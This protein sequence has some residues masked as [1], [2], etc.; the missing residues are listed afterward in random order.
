V[1]VNLFCFQPFRF[2]YHL[3]TDE[4]DREYEDHHVT[5]QE[6]W[7]VPTIKDE[8]RIASNKSHDETTGEGIPCTKWLPPR[9]VWERVTRESLSLTRILEFDESE[10]HDG[11]IDKLG[12]SDLKDLA[13]LPL[14]KL[15]TTHQAYEPAQNHGGVVA[16]LQKAQQC[17]QEDNCN[18]IDGHPIPGTFF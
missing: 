12:S 16:D 2:L 7:D 3:P 15:D 9:F 11:K 10:S 1:E 17:D 18:A 4:Q 8:D 6:G 13:T 14:M 5:E